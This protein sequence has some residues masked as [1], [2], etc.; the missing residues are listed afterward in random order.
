MV[1]VPELIILNVG[2]GNC[3]IL[4]DTKAIT[5]IDCGSDGL[6]LIET[7]RQLEIVAVDH[8]IVFH[9]DKDHS[10]GLK[11]LLE[12][13][14]VHHLYLNADASKK[15]QAWQNI[16]LAL[17]V[18]ESSGTEV[19]IG[20]TSQFSKKI[21]SGEVEIEILAP[22]TSLAAIGPGGT[23]PGGHALDSNTLSVVIGLIHK[24]C[25][26]ALHSRRYGRVQSQ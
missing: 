2:H 8:I 11:P 3:A 1:D 10:G 12:A 19:H 25:R 22:S 21:I 4:R 24:S 6:S 23:Y 17:D 15:S 13:F 14:P 26:V 5:V 20:L 16:A 9:A 18:A 7:L